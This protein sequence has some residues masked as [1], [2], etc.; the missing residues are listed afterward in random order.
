MLDNMQKNNT[1]YIYKVD[2]LSK[3]IGT[4]NNLY[5]SYSNKIGSVQSHLDRWNLLS[6]KEKDEIIDALFT[7]RISPFFGCHSRYKNQPT[8]C[9]RRKSNPSMGSV[10]CVS[11]IV[12]E[13]ES[14]CRQV[15]APD[16][17]KKAYLPY[18]ESQARCYGGRM[19]SMDAFVSW[20][21]SSL[22]SGKNTY[23][24]YIQMRYL[25]DSARK[26]NRWS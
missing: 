7:V 1:Q 24:D 25:G 13:I 22:S 8:P 26:E 12:D 2:L 20:L 18:I 17:C 21:Y 19:A 10:D 3:W 11:G 14:S 5:F 23:T 9:Y 6:Q 15:N 16:F 4:I